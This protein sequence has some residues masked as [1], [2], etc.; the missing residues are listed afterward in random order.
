MNF[1]EAQAAW[2]RDRVEFERLG[3]VLPGV[4]SYIPDEFKR[5]YALAMDSLGEA[6][7]GNLAYDALPTLSTDPNAGIPSIL[8]TMVDPEV[9]EIVF[10][11]NKAA[12]IIGEVKKGDWLMDTTLFPVAE[13]TGEVSSYG[14]Y[15]ENGR[16]GV[17]TAFPGRQSYLY[18]LIKRY[19]ER[20][21][22]RAGLAK[23]NWVSEIDKAAVKSLRKFENFSYFFGIAGLQNYGLLNDPNLPASLT[24]A[25]KA[26]GGTAWIQGGRIVATPN[27]IYADVEAVYT[28][29]VAQTLGLV[30]Q[31]SAMILA[32][33]TTP[34]TA[35]TATNSFNVNVKDLLTKNF[36]KLKVITA[37]QYQV[38]SASNTQGLAAGNLMQL[39]APE[40]E[41]QRTG[42]CAFNEKLRNHPIIRLMSAFQQKATAGTW[43]TV[44]RMPMGVA[45]MLGI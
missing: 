8:T 1:R 13:A 35:F 7:F 27:E 11:A 38:A 29:L 31:E 14:D 36:P 19:G 21:L 15:N 4:R 3:I 18:Q 24:P 26:A 9:F 32:L 17:N 42:F 2:Q 41:G 22:E 43:G 25:V 12:E 28:Q 5:D 16:A 20:E 6:G 10:A 40:I 37:V 45:S 44:L 34:S 33:G 23:I 30:E 39:I